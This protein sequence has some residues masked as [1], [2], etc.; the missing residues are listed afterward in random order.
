MKLSRIRLHNFRKFRDIDFEV[1]NQNIILFIGNN[2]SG[3]T[4]ILDAISKCFSHIIGFLISQQENYSIEDYLNISDITNGEAS[5]EITTEFFKGEILTSI[6]IS[7]NIDQKGS[8][9]NY[10]K[11]QIQSIRN[12]IIDGTRSNLPLFAYYRINRTF[13]KQEEYS[14]SKFYKP[15]LFGYSNSVNPKKSP[16]VD[17]DNW[18]IGLENRENEEIIRRKDFNYKNS[19]LEALRENLK[20]FLSK[21]YEKSVRKISVTRENQFEGLNFNP[22]DGK[23]VIEFDGEQAPILVSQLSAGEKMIFYIVA[24]ISR[25][26]LILNSGELNKHSGI[27]LID[28]IDL[29]LHPRWQ[30]NILPALTEVFPNLQFVCTTHSP[31][32]LSMVQ[33]VNIIEIESELY[34]VNSNPLGGDSNRILEELFETPERPDDRNNLINDIYQELESDSIKYDL[35]NTKLEQLKMLVS[36]DDPVLVKLNNYI[37]RRKLLSK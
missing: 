10:D 20:I 11:R 17:F 37:N 14:E 2:G 21:F 30:R 31:Q 4:S 36:E 26:L 13:F 23:V 35:V 33:S 34:E 16:F 25:R 28:E 7:R 8:K 1:P 27:V 32:V 6:G 9:Y 5:V 24:D 15:I 18:F 3:K 12:G 22:S 19:E 29:H